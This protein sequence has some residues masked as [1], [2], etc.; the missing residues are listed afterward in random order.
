MTKLINMFMKHKHHIIPKHAGGTDDPENLIELTIED[1]AEAHRLLWEE[2][3]RW[4]DRV[5]WLSLSGMI[6]HEERIREIL[7]NSNKGNL[8]GYKMSYEQRQKLSEN[9]KKE[10][11]PM[12]GKLGKDNPRY[13]TSLSDETKE[14]I[15]N[16]LLGRKWSDETR[17][18]QEKIRSQLGYYNFLQNKERCQK[19]SESKKGKPGA[20]TGKSWYNNGIKETYDFTCPEGYS[21]GRLKRK[22]N[23]KKGLLWY[24]NGVE[25]KQFSLGKQPEGWY[26]GRTL[27][28]KQ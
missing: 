3:G 28:K 20:A 11:N 13:G 16:S 4:Q 22:T 10:K 7:S 18:K 8:T 2:Y 5:A 25:S 6:G 27:N 14:K 12:Y 17:K 26:R 21:K 23:G 15:S 9:R 19:I 1:H 24:T